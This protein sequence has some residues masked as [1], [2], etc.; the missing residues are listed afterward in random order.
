M[1]SKSDSSTVAGGWCRR[2]PHAVAITTERDVITVGQIEQLSS[3]IAQ[4]VRE[5]GARCVLLPSSEPV[6]FLA[7]LLGC[8]RE[9]VVVVPW[10][11]ATLSADGLIEVVRPDGIL[12][13]DRS[14]APSAEVLP[15]AGPSYSGQ[16][17]G[18]L[19]MMTSGSTGAPKGVALEMGS[20]ILNAMSAG[21]VMKVDRCEGWAIEIDL[22]LMSAVSH[23]LMAWQFDLPLHHLAGRTAEQCGRLFAGS[24][25]GYG[26]SPV[27]LVRLHERLGEDAAPV[28]M[29]SSGDFLT[30]SM[31]E[32][33]L[34][35]YPATLI[36]KL[37]GLTELSGR[38]CCMPH[39]KL[40]QDSG[41]V[42]APLPGFEARVREADDNGIGEI[43]ARSPLL[44]LGYYRQGGVF[45]PRDQTWF[46]TG[47]IGSI[48]NGVVSL[49]GRDDDVV[50]VLG[51]K[52]DRVSIEQALSGLLGNR[53]FCVLG[54]DHPLTG[55]CP[56]LFLAGDEGSLPTWRE[57][58]TT[59]RE[60]LSSRFVPSLMYRVPHALPRLEN[61]KIDRNQLKARHREFPRLT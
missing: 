8:S 7:G 56:G 27:Q 30:P 33:I 9:G 11:D 34:A 21:A 44:F 17:P 19:I 49:S 23:L 18:D 57:I 3:I 54:L 29:A 41:P 51:E 12:S 47:D 1:V 46:A 20:V 28:M 59:I 31:V 55:R 10:R 4:S 32:G 35:R 16:R 5:S 42:G 40:L 15:V 61:G 24:A 6:T 50:K 43:E 22:A 38:F 53:D 52:V 48:A 25:I 45:E 36:H 58:V 13:V 26:G 37:Y 14:P 60:T 2:D 39:A